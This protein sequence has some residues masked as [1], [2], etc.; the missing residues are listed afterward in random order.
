MPKEYVPQNIRK[1]V[2]IAAQYRCE[3]CQTAQE[4]SGA[5]MNIEHIIPLSREGS[6]EESNL[7]L[8]CIWCNSYKWAHVDGIDSETGQ[9]T[10][11][12]HPRT[13]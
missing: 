5:Q 3:Y 9:K 12:F 6:S 4:I 13:Q 10:P 11:L 2:S 8:S 7:C 1:K